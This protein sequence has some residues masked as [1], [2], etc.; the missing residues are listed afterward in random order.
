MTMAFTPSV[1]LIARTK[2][3]HESNSV[4]M[5]LATTTEQYYPVYRRNQ[6]PYITFDGNTGFKLEMKAVSSFRETDKTEDTLFNYNS[7]DVF[8]PKKTTPPSPISWP[9]GDGRGVPMTGPQGAFTQPNVKEYGPF[10]D[11][12]K[13]SESVFARSPFL[14]PLLLL[15]WR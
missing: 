2:H 10:P 15:H 4:C 3:S 6:A 14:P 12:Y 11:F 9:S 5:K 7:D 8:E 1:P 13:V